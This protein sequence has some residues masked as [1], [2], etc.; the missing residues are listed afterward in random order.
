MLTVFHLYAVSVNCGGMS[1]ENCTYFDSDTTMAGGCQATICPC[2]DN[3]CQ[4]FSA[5]IM[6]TFH[7]DASCV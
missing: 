3:I 4:V 7:A 1:S 2:N 6:I 5:E